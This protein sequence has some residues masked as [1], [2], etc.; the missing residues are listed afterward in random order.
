MSEQKL[1]R[2]QLAIGIAVIVIAAAAGIFRAVGCEQGAAVTDAVGDA[3]GDVAD[4]VT[5]DADEG[6]E[7]AAG[8][9]GE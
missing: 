6:A 4:V 7:G 9:E 5:P 2:W 1:K 8:A 3:V